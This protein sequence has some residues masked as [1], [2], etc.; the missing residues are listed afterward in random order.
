MAGTPAAR[1]RRSEV[2]ARGA[3]D[4]GGVDDREP[5]ARANRRTSER[6]SA[7]N[8]GRVAAWSPGSPAIAA[9]NASDER[10]S[11]G[12]K[13]RAANVDLPA[14]A[15]PTRTTSDGSGSSMT[16]GP[17]IATSGRLP[18]AARQ[19]WAGDS[20]PSDGGGSGVGGSVGFGVLVGFGVGLGVGL[21]VALGVGFGS[22]LLSFGG[23][24][25]VDDFDGLRSGPL[26]GSGI[27]SNRASL[28]RVP[29][30]GNSLAAFLR[31]ALTSGIWI[32]PRAS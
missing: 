8:A 4:A 23:S 6:W 9:R 12:A 11:S 16:V 17:V 22:G 25:Q 27:G 21:G 14:P 24:P 13:W 20:L 30:G 26:P 5:S 10:T 15:A 19:G 7:E 28:G 1:A 31:I 18:G 29:V 32:E 3:L 2:E